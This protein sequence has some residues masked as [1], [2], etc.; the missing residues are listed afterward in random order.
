MV[1]HEAPSRPASILPAGDP[2]ARLAG[3]AA[4][5]RVPE[6]LAP[7]P[8]RVRAVL[9]LP[10]EA[11]ATAAG[12]ALGAVVM[13]L[14]MGR[15]GSRLLGTT[16]LGLGLLMIADWDFVGVVGGLAAV[17]IGVAGWEASFR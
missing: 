8:P 17:V 10:R 7:D 12:E 11:V 9:A 6:L 13:R 14:P 2:A 1:P 15:L 3:R 16:M 5:V 4:S